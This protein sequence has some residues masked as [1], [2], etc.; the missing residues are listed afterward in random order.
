MTYS[1][2]SLSAFYDINAV[3]LSTAYKKI[4]SSTLTTIGSFEEF[5]KT[6]ITDMT[7][8]QFK[9]VQEGWFHMSEVKKR[10]PPITMCIRIFSMVF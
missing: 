8:D 10:N 6:T 4:L 7:I 2:S 9:H 1:N 3:N 5:Y